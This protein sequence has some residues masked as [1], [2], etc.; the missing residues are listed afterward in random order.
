MDQKQ[1]LIE[2]NKCSCSFP[3]E[4]IK[5]YPRIVAKGNMKAIAYCFQCPNCRQEYICYFKDSEVN[6]LF[7][8]GN[9]EKARQRMKYLK[10]VF[11]NG[12][13]L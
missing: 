3:A 4:E 8:D 11:T 9:F 13:P 7:R 2:C 6:H 5:I 12:N 1:Q 10:E